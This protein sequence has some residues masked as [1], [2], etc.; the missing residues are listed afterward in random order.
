[1][2]VAAPTV[3]RSRQ[4]TTLFAGSANAGRTEV[5]TARILSITMVHARSRQSSTSAPSVPAGNCQRNVGLRKDASPNE[6]GAI[7]RGKAP[8]AM[9]AAPTRSKPALQVAEH[10][11]IAQTA[12]PLA[13]AGHAFPQAP[14]LATSLVVMT[15]QPL[16]AVLS[17]LPKPVLHMATPQIPAVQFGVALTTVHALPHMPQFET[18]VCKLRHVIMAPAPQGLLGKGQPRRHTPATHI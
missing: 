10:A 9:Q 4:N 13:T 16:A 12:L 15:S 14:Q 8:I 5:P 18:S 7:G 3:A 1:M 17:Q 11:L 6:S 2:A